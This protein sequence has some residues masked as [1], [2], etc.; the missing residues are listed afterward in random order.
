MFSHSP[1]ENELLNNMEFFI[2]Q[3]DYKFD[4]FFYDFE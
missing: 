3:I 2:K 1:D 4:K